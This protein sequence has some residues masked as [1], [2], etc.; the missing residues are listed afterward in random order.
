[1]QLLYDIEAPRK[2]HGQH[3][4]TG[5]EG[6]QVGELTKIRAKNLNSIFTRKVFVKAETLFH[7]FREFCSIKTVLN[8]RTGNKKF[9]F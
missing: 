8:V 6:R 9:F 2:T 5:N 3:C 4:D 7:P 1:M